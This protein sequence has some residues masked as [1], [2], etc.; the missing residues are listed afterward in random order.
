MIDQL[1]ELFTLCRD[2]RERQ[3]YAAALAEIS[4]SSDDAV[5]VVVTLRD[6]FLI[7]AD[8]L[9]PL[10][11]RL[12]RGIKLLTTPAP[13]DLERI[14]VEPA[15][16]AGYQFEDIGLVGEMVDAVAGQPGALALLSFTAAELWTLRDRQ[17]RQISRRAYGAIGG[18]GGALARHAET[19]LADMTAEEKRLTREAFRHLVTAEGT[20]QVLKL[21][22]LR[23]LLGGGGRADAV[24]DRLTSA[25]LVVI[26]EEAGGDERVEIIHEALLSAWPRLVE[27]RKE[28]AEGARMRDQLRTAARQW[29]ARGRPK[30]LLWRADALAEYRI[31]RARYPGALTDVEDTFGKTSVADA[32]RGTRIRRG[33]LVAAFAVLAVGLTIMYQLREGEAEQRAL[34]HEKL[35]DSFEERG[36]QALLAGESNAALV[37]LSEALAMGAD[38]P[39]VR[40]MIAR[41]K[42]PL[43]AELATMRGHAGPVRVVEI[44]S[45][46]RRVLTAGQDGTARVWDPTGANV[47]TLDG[48]ATGWL[49]AVW[50]RDGRIITGD[51]AG[52]VRFWGADGA[53]EREVRAGDAAIIWI[54]LDPTRDRLAVADAAGMATIWDVA[55]GTRVA[56]WAA[57]PDALA[58]IQFDP[59]G[60]RV[61]TASEAHNVVRVW[62]DRGSLLASLEGH[63]SRVWYVQFDPTGR[64]IATASLDYTAR[65][66]DAAT[67]SLAHVLDRHEGR[68]TWV[69]F[70][71]SGQ[72]L[73]TAGG[74]RTVRIWD[75]ASG[76]LRATLRGHTAQV[77][78]V[79][80]ARG[81]ELVITIGVDGTAR[82]WD[83]TTGMQTAVYVH[84][85]FVGAMSVDSAGERLATAS[86]SDET[87]KLWDLT[88]QA[89]AASYRSFDVELAGAVLSPDGTS[90]VRVGPGGL[91]RWDVSTGRQIDHPIDVAPSAHAISPDGQV[92]AAGD[93]SGTIHVIVDGRRR[94]FAAHT[95]IVKWVGFDRAGQLVTGSADG[96]IARWSQDGQLV[97]RRELPAPADAAVFAPDRSRFV[98]L[99]ASGAWLVTDDLHEIVPLPAEGQTYAATF[100]PDSQRI[101]TGDNTGNTGAIRVWGARGA[102]LRTLKEAGAISTLAWTAP[103]NLIAGTAAGEVSSWDTTTWRRVSIK[104]HDMLVYSAATSPDGLLVATSGLDGTIKL[105]SAGTLASL[106]VLAEGTATPGGDQG[107]KRNLSFRDA[108]ELVT[109]VEQSSDLWNMQPYAGT[110]EAL[111]AFVECHVPRRIEDASR[112]VR[113]VPRC[114]GSSR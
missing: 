112:L 77:N 60:S 30:G 52:V 39:E 32:A 48:H 101:V 36:R 67:G 81:G 24:I 19:T 88:R 49:R 41:A 51:R 43:D 78:A 61:V 71:P 18:V 63:R 57:D 29:D 31:W 103:G 1:E 104:A 33:L 4:R 72:R 27:W 84:D 54:A 73:A 83:A 35:A 10:R 68:V 99:G 111:Q 20:R 15:K 107:A 108:T 34:V 53:K 25:R 98:A 97:T 100:A 114:P 42:E 102:P 66:W 9:V 50:A 14:L 96:T 82:V 17:F 47:L 110:P 94:S 3:A 79:T 85:G 16:R 44:D 90:L 23:Q 21:T 109:S 86:W 59:S 89:R 56:G 105:W 106:F 40:F 38:R 5:R 87:A 11:D 28:D 113:V 2:D 62:S 37:Y 8:A 7:Q 45:T 65:I 95:A 91:V 74:D 80:F 22:E 58:M 69:A 76:E 70:D 12:A 64:W 46:G 93:A 26:A 13:E 75:V 92:V 6:D 55:T